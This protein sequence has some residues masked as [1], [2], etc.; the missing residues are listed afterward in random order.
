MIECVRLR[1]RLFE[2]MRLSKQCAAYD[3]FLSG[4]K[5]SVQI[6][7]VRLRPDTL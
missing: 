6:Q 3:K 7:I 4:V 2:W 1:V 5:S